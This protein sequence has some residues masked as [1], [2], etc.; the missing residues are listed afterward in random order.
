MT[1]ELMADLVDEI[2]KLR[3]A[4]EDLVKVVEKLGESV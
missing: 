1:P 4:V 3:Y 2:Q